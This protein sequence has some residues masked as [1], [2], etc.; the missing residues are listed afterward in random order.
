MNDR[1]IR[2]STHILVFPPY[3]SHLK[4]PAFA[5]RFLLVGV[6]GD[7]VASDGDI[8][9]IGV[10]VHFAISA[11]TRA[12]LASAKES[13]AEPKPGKFRPYSAPSG[14]QKVLLP[15]PAGQA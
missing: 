3:N 15:Q 14:S 9:P 12:S 13:R 11:A 10:D 4:R 5:L 2:R 6:E 7:G 8:A 1:Q